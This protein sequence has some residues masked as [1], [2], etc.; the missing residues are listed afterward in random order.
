MACN[1][2]D[3]AFTNGLMRGVAA[4]ACI[5]WFGVFVL[6]MVTSVSETV[7]MSVASSAFRKLVPPVKRRIGSRLR[8][9]HAESKRLLA[10]D[11]ADRAKQRGSQ[12]V[13]REQKKWHK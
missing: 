5:A 6:L 1:S 8:N 7:E 4:V 9:A 13:E 11:W 12:D 10:T 3:R 2:D